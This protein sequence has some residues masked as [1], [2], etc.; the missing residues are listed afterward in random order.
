M[1]GLI[2]PIM[3]IASPRG[4]C[5]EKSVY[6]KNAKVTIMTKNLGLIEIKVK[7]VFVIM[8]N[9]ICVLLL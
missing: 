9:V 2:S 8:E 3:A 4:I 1:C 5:D 7:D 6:K